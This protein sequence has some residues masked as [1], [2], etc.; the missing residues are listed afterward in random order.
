[1]PARRIAET[2]G[3]RNLITFDMGGTRSDAALLT[4]GECRIVNE[5]V[6]RG[7]SIK[8]PMLDIH[9]VCA[10]GGAIA[11]VDSGGLLKVGL[12]SAGAF[13]GPACYGNGNPEPT[14]TDANVVLQT[15][16]PEYPL[17]NRMRIDLRTSFAATRLQVMDA[18]GIGRLH[19]IFDDLSAC[20]RVVDLLH[21]VPAPVVPDRATAAGNGRR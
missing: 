14:V 19:A 1:M 8:T 7:Y 10:G 17:N 6:V 12:R 2:T 13:P 15:L 20:Q 21:G 9:T 16:N 4:D 3:I 11:Y 5:S 18:E